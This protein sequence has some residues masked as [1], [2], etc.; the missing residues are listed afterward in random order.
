MKHPIQVMVWC[1]LTENGATNPYF[2]NPK[3]TINQLNYRRKILRHAKKEGKRLFDSANWVIF[4]NLLN[5][6]LISFF[7][8]FFSF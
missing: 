8:F 4:Q 3:E 2:L 7:F 5:F 6:L 1:G